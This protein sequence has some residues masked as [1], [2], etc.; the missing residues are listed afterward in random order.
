MP[1]IFVL[2][3]RKNSIFLSKYSTIYKNRGPGRVWARGYKT[4]EHE[5]LNAHKY[6]NIKKYSMFQAQISLE[7]YFLA[8]KC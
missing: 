3:R 8:H 1:L 5:I 6:E 4:V 7:C 2:C